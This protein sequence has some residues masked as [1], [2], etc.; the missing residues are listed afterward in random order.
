MYCCL[1]LRTLHHDDSTMT[2]LFFKNLQFD[3][4]KQSAKYMK[5]K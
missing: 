3:G 5:D 2:F 1:N 4:L